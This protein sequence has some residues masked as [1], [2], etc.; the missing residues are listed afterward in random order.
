LSF[1]HNTIPFIAE[2]ERRDYVRKLHGFLKYDERFKQIAYHSSFLEFIGFVTIPLN[3]FFFKE[4]KSRVY[5]FDMHFSKLLG[6]KNNEK[7]E[8]FQDMILVKPPNIGREKP[9]HQDHAYFVTFLFAFSLML[10]S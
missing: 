9:W 8:V 1:S 6:L 7:P 2:E 3:I 4:V 10:L 5:N